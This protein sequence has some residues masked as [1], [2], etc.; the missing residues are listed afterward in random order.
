MQ[1]LQVCSK[2]FVHINSTTLRKKREN[3]QKIK[4]YYNKITKNTHIVQKRAGKDRKNV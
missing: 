2:K 3:K 1:M 4:E